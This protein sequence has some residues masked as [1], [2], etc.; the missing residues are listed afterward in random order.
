MD[1][2]PKSK[3]IY[4]LN[5]WKNKNK[6]SKRA[7]ASRPSHQKNHAKQTTPGQNLK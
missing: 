7:I 6:T 3:I 5:V 4:E 2:L 1:E